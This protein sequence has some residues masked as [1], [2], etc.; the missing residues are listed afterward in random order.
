[1]PTESPKPATC[2]L[3]TF[4]ENPTPWLARAEQEPV[5]LTNN[6]YRVGVF[7][8]VMAYD[9]LLRDSRPQASPIT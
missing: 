7:L 9:R 4:M 2:A 6:G 5:F 8:G 1:M 3:S